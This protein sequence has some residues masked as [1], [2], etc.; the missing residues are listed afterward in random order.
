MSHL[1]L[2]LVDRRWAAL[3]WSSSPTMWLVAGLGVLL[4]CVVVIEGLDLSQQIATARR[5]RQDLVSQMARRTNADASRE[6]FVNIAPERAQAINAAVHQLNLPWTELMEALEAAS[7]PEVAVLEWSPQAE[8]GTLKGMA[9]ARTSDDMINFARKLKAQNFFTSVE[10]TSHQ[11][12][13]QDRNKP[14][15]FDFL[16]TWTNP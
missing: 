16:V 15:R 12:N 4:L 2:N 8:A 9:E 10:L 6:V 14:L 13:E 1:R 11:V 5:A 7:I 3:L